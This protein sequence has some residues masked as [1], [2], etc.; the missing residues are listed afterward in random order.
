MLDSFNYICH[1]SL[2]ADGNED[3]NIITMNEK[4]HR[5]NRF[6]TYEW[7]NLYVDTMTGQKVACPR[8]LQDP[9]DLQPKLFF[10]FQDLCIRKKGIY[11]LVCNI[12]NMDNPFETCQSLT[13]SS[14]Q[15]YTTQM[16]PGGIEPTTLSKSF[17]IQGIC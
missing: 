16:F 3:G 1:V 4:R 11:R 6:G 8:I 15:V 5:R 7:M 13:S 12:V 17:W 2:I 10:V 9:K 14:F